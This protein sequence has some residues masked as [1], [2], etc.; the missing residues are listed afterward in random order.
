MLASLKPR[1]SKRSLLLLG[2]ALLPGAVMPQSTDGSPVWDQLPI[3]QV[4]EVNGQIYVRVMEQRRGNLQPIE[5]L[6]VHRATTM[7][8]HTLCQYTPKPNQRLEAKLQG[9]TLIHSKESDQRVREVVIR[10]KKQKPECIVQTIASAPPPSPAGSVGNPPATQEVTTESGT[11]PS[12]SPT[13]QPTVEPIEVQTNAT[14]SP[15]QG[16]DL[17][18]KVQ[19][20]SKEY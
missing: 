13:L 19:S 16:L 10:L 5:S 14:P 15:I 6:L 17:G 3:N 7:A 1:V 18:V 9:V 4:T 2:F 20:L 12:G 11:L 8:A